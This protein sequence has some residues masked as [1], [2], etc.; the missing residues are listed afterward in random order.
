MPSSTCPSRIRLRARNAPPVRGRSPHHRPPAPCPA[1]GRKQPASLRRAGQVR[2]R[3]SPEARVS[4][5]VEPDGEKEEPEK[6]NQNDRGRRG[7]PPPP[8]IN[9]RSVE[10]DPIKRHAQGRRVNG[11]EAQHFE[12]DRSEDR[13]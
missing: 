6:D 11:A 3:A 12:P 13:G 9:H 5:L 10:I 7:P 1:D 4:D 8:T 2:S